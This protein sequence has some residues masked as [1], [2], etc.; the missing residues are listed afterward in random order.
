MIYT[1]SKNNK[2]ETSTMYKEHLLNAFVKALNEKFT[3][4]HGSEEREKALINVAHLQ[5]EILKRL[6]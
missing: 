3:H 6:K 2:I 1:D 4:G 5:E